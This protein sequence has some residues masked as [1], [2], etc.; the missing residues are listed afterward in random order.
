MRFLAL[1]AGLAVVTSIAAASAQTQTRAGHDRTNNVKLT[2]TKWFAPGFPNMVGVVG[3]DVDGTFG[4]A[5]LE[6]TPDATGQSVHLKAIYI[7][8]ATDPTKSFTAEV[9][10]VQDNHTAKAVLDGR[11]I[12]GRLANAQV[13]AEYS[14][15]SCT[16]A[17][18][19][20]CF[21]GTISIKR[22][23]HD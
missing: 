4:G 18:N 16:Q 5:V 22:S 6:A 19:G 1:I 10:G 20:T 9:E 14:V 23:S 3:G 12:Q 8:I 21:Q 11:V 17:P 13:H 2:Y 15:I 7:V